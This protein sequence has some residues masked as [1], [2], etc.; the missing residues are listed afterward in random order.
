MLNSWYK[1]DDSNLNERQKGYIASLKLLFRVQYSDKQWRPYNP[2]PYQIEYHSQSLV[3]LEHKAR[4]RLVIKSR[5]VSFTT[6]TVIDLIMVAL[7]YP[8][9]L[10]PI[11]GQDFRAGLDIVK[12]TKNIIKHMQTTTIL[13]SNECE[14][15]E[16]EVRMPNS[17]I[18]RAYPSSISAE[19]LRSRRLI[20]GLLDETAIQRKFKDIHTAIMGASSGQYK[21]KSLFQLNSGTTLKG[22]SSEYYVQYE[23]A[24]KFKITGTDDI[25]L[26]LFEFPVFN[27]DVFI[28]TKSIL[29]QNLI[30]IAPWHSLADLEQKRTEDLSIFLS[31]YMIIA[32]NDNQNYIT[33]DD[34]LKAQNPKLTND[35]PKTIYPL[36]GGFDVAVT[37]DYC[38]LCVF[39]KIDDDYIMR[40]Y[41]KFPPPV[42]L[43]EMQEYLENFIK[44][45]NITIFRIDSTGLGTQIG[46]YLSKRFLGK[47]QPI[48]FSSSDIN[49][50]KYRERM[51]IELRQLFV[52]EKIKIQND[53]I[54]QKHLLA[55][56]QN[57]KAT[58][59]IEG[60]ADSFWAVALACMQ[61]EIKK[62]HVPSIVGFARRK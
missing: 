45:N 22:R 6:S 27:P 15:L 9:T 14:F 33:F 19:S 31:E 18:I 1:F 24:K 37:R 25:G 50:Q 26:D 42:D 30:P 62:R 43:T 34:I 54:L 2:L 58:H 4:N 51:A 38:I 41:E 49:K 48:H 57:L 46:Q 36:I 5:N 3:A 35:I 29:E 32:L 39:E 23:K 20:T 56:K 47:V 17:S 53:L 61:E 28:P 59:T 13:N 12:D 55:V 44:D 7:K 60:H 11:I 52:A 16:G 40:W 10:I 8:D 21:G